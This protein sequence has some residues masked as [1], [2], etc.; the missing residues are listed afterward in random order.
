MISDLDALVFSLHHNRGV[1]ALLLGSGVS[2]AAQVPTGWEVIQDLIRKLAQSQGEEIPED[3]EQWC[4]GL[5]W[6]L[7][8]HKT[9]LRSQ[10][11]IFVRNWAR[12]ASRSCRSVP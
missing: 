9:R 5:F 12:R 10:P 4:R 7:D 8:G 3:P 11:P 6:R 2:K 1:Y